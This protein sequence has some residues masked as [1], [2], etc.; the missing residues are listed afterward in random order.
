MFGGIATVWIGNSLQEFAG[1]RR[2][3]EFDSIKTKALA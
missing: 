2:Q 3:A 1:K